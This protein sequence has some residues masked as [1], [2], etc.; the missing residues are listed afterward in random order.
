MQL[1]VYLHHGSPLEAVMHVVVEVGG[2]CDC[3][4]VEVCTCVWGRK[5]CV[6]AG[7]G[8]HHGSPLEAI[9]HVVVE[10]GGRCVCVFGGGRCVC[11]SVCVC[12]C[13]CLSA[14]SVSLPMLNQLGVYLH[15]GPLKA[16]MHVVVICMLFCFVSL[17]RQSCSVQSKQS[18][19]TSL[20]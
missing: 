9:M 4:C 11:V 16:V 8:L 19:P 17:L 14:A 20:R 18:R 15:D 1:G 10:V 6:W 12:V 5:I 13:V 2:R 3:V 7:V